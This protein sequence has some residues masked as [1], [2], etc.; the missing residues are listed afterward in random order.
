MA[1]EAIADPFTGDP[2][3]DGWHRET[4][5]L[6]GHPT[7]YYKFFWMIAQKYKPRFVV[8][9][10]SWRAYGAAHFA[11]GCPSSHV[12]T[13]DIH[14]DD[15]AAHQRALEV[16][17]HYDNLGFIHS[18]TWDAAPVV[19]AMEKQI[20]VLYIDAWHVYEY[21]KREWELYTP[22]LAPH[23]L[24]LMDD[25]FNAEGACEGMVEFWQEYVEGQH[26]AFLDAGLHWGIPFGVVEWKTA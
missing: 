24:I 2:T 23:A 17:A 26:A 11:G 10:G 22:L 21:V 9:L 13:V 18:W 25:V 4:E 15:Q 8:E 3:L 20:D 14:K 1:T 5:V 12:V 7:P 19:K 16:A 6:V